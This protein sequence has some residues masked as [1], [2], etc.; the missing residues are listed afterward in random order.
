[1]RDDREAGEVDE[2]CESD[3]PSD[4][5]RA[6]A[7]RKSE[8]LLLDVV[9]WLEMKSDSNCSPALCRLISLHYDVLA[10]HREVVSRTEIVGQ[11]RRRAAH[12][13]LRAAAY[14]RCAEQTATAGAPPERS[15]GSGNSRKDKRFPQEDLI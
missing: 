7:Q 13:R 14:V 10:E 3:G 6:L 11:Y 2:V 8:R 9:T 5:L 12:W 1:M 4:S 15:D